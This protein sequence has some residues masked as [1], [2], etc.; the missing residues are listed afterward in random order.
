MT[1]SSATLKSSRSEPPITEPEAN[2]WEKKNYSSATGDALSGADQTQEPQEREKSAGFC[3]MGAVG[4]FLIC[5]A[6]TA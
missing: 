3:S 6:S 2:Q 4:Y 5:K 1:I